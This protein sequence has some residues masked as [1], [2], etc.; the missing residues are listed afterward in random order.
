M[1]NSRY[2]IGFDAVKGAENMSAEEKMA[3]FEE[4]FSLSIASPVTCPMV[5]AM[6]HR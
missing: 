3:A 6:S 1:S 4:V 2:A 5:C